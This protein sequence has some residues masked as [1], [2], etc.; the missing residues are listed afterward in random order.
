MEKEPLVEEGKPRLPWET[1]DAQKRMKAT[2]ALLQQM[3][4]GAPR[5][6]EGYYGMHQLLAAVTREPAMVITPQEAQMVGEQVYR[7]IVLYDL[8]WLLK[9]TP[10][11]M[12]AMSIGMVEGNTVR[13][14]R[15]H[16]AERRGP[17][18]VRPEVVPPPEEEAPEEPSPPAPNGRPPV[19]PET[20]RQMFG[21]PG[22][23]PVGEPLEE[24]LD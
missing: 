19:D 9:Y 6:A 10:L 7:C 16:R 13:R 24:D 2:E 21:T 12:L 5:V 18:R 23:D 17:V 20:L 1:P 22:V 3:G 11:V 15:A 14:V 4:L 8:V